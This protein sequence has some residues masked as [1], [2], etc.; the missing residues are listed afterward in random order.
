MP[1]PQPRALRTLAEVHAAGARRGAELGPLT[2]A[3]ADRVAAI[4]AP[5]QQPATAS[6]AA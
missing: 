2:Q 4:L 5:Y 6:R 3:Q 1:A